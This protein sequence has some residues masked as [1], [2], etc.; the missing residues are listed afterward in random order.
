MLRSLLSGK[1]SSAAWHGAWP[2]L[3]SLG[4]VEVLTAEECAQLLQSMAEGVETLLPPPQGLHGGIA[5]V[6]P[7][8]YAQS[9]MLCLEVGTI[10]IKAE[11][12]AASGGVCMRMQA[13]RIHGYT[14]DMHAHDMH[15]ALF[16]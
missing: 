5:S 3:D 4:I 11:S 12:L 14:A 1:R 13:C 8:C 7:C 2:S 6:P 15:G 16:R 10:S 9:E